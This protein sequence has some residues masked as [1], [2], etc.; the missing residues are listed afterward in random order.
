MHK[1]DP[2]FD[3]THFLAGA[4]AAFRMI[5]T[6]FTEGARDK[7]RPLLTDVTFRAFD[8]AIALRN[9]TQQ[10]AHTQIK[11]MVD[12]NI[13]EARLAGNVAAITVRFVSNQI[14]YTLDAQGATIAGTDAVTEIADIWRFERDLTAPD[15]AWRLAAARSA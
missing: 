11:E 15:L 6:A 5:V 3:P 2:R 4:E 12:I 9:T 1:I 8:Q 7:L 14:N 10:T 13:E